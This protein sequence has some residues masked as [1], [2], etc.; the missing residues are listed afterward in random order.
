MGIVPELKQFVRSFVR[1]PYDT[2]RF[3]VSLRQSLLNAWTICKHLIAPIE[4]LLLK[5]I[6]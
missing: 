5:C 3:A 1:F 6:C 2:E 4:A